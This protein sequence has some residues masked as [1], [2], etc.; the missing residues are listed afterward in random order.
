MK[1]NFYT[2][3]L[4][5]VKEGKTAGFI[6]AWKRFGFVLSEVPGSPPA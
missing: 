6:E 5:Y 3:A 4:W 1:D 2:H